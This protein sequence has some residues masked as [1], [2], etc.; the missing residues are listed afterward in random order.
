MNTPLDLE[1]SRA[2][3]EL[4]GWYETEKY[5]ERT[6]GQ[7]S[8]EWRLNDRKSCYL[9]DMEYIPAPIFGEALRI[10]TK[11]IPKMNDRWRMPVKIEI[12]H[13]AAALSGMYVSAPTEPQ[14]MRD[15]GKYLIKLLK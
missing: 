2:I 10:L 8:P 1:T 3:F 11:I 12:E 13:H 7:V 14:A 6:M 9:K 15:V 5:W 4:V